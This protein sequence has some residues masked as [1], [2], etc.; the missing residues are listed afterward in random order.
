AG[1]TQVNVMFQSASEGFSLEPLEFGGSFPE[2]VHFTMFD[3]TVNATSDALFVPGPIAGAGLPGL[4]LAAGGLIGWWRSASEVG[5]TYGLGGS[6]SRK[7][8][9]DFFDCASY[10]FGYCV[11]A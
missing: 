8:R 3:L 4:I 10:A 6:G 11:A 1:N 5:W 2:V 9:S 7:Q